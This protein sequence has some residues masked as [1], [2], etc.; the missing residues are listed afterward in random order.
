MCLALTMSAQTRR[1]LLVGLS[2][3][4][5]RYGWEKISGTNDIDLIKPCLKGFTLTE[6]KNE[7]ATFGAIISSLDLLAHKSRSGDIVYIHFSGHGQPV[8]DS[9]GD[10]PDGWD[11]SFVPYDAGD[12]FVKGKY[13]GEC[14]LTD[15]ILGRKLDAI[16]KVIGQQGILY[17]VLDACHAGQGYRGNIMDDDDDAPERGSYVGLSENKIYRPKVNTTQHYRL[18]ASPS[19]AHVIMMEACLPEQ[20]NREIKVGD[21]YYGPLSYSVYSVIKGKSLGK[22]SSWCKSVEDMFRKIIPPMSSQKMVIE[23]SIR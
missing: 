3:Y 2:E 21:K 14:H 23:S 18:E 20:L 12:M 13:E 9:N 5:S 19:M 22:D 8:E 11:E 16:R 10:E 1:A 15:D 7:R 4:D 6:L 17:V